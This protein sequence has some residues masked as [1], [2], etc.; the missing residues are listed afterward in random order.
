[1]A[2]DRESRE[3]LHIGVDSMQMEL[4]LVAETR[5]DGC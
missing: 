3:G 5:M 1:M 4:E 2:L